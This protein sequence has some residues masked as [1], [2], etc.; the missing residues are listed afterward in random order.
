MTSTVGGW[1]VFAAAIG[2]MMTL[3]S[4]EV[5]GLQTWAAALTPAFVGKAMAHVG[6]VIAAF[7]GGKLIPTDR[8]GELTRRTD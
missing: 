4:G 5:V 2:M 8:T 1:I 7:I 6:V 3:L